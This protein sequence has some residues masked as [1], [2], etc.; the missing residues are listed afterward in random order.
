M[1]ETTLR[2]GH[3]FIVRI[4]E[5]ADRKNATSGWRGSVQHVPSGQQL[6][7]A[8]LRD[9]NDFITLKTGCPSSQGDA[10]SYPQ[11]NP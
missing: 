10:K 11:T 1:D 9:M 5:E 7:F 2:Q 8:S 4:W 3:L 6:Y